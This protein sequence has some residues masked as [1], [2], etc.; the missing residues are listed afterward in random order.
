[1]SSSTIVYDTGRV[2]SFASL[3]VPLNAVVGMHGIGL[4]HDGALVAGV[5]YE[6]FNG[7]N[8]WMHVAAVPGKKWLTRAYL[9]ACFAYPFVQCGVDRISGYVEANN[10]EARRFDEHLG[11]E[12]EAVLRGAAK[13]GGDVIIYAMWKEGCRYV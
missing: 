3:L 12:Q 2:F 13:D 4:E 8:I 11:F 1:M 10:A 7:R 5:I 9:A 6:G